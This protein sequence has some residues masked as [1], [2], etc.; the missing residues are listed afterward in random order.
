[1]NELTKE[2]T[3]RQ[4]LLVDT[5]VATGCTITEASQIAG[6]AKGDSGRVSA[7]KALR[8]HK[9]QQYMQSLVMN[10]IGL[11]ATKASIR[12]MQLSESAKSEY[13]QLEASKDILDRAGY[14]APDKH[15]HL[16]AGDIKVTIDLA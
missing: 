5:L 15:M 2:L 7:S 10:S 14:K 6:Y 8:T 9:V 13:V 11:N 1:M 16:H 3:P 12:L 4:I